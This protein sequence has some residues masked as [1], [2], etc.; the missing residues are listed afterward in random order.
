[1]GDTMDALTGFGF[2]VSSIVL[3]TRVVGC[4]Y[5]GGKVEEKI[6][7]DDPY[8][9]NIA[10]RGT[11]PFESFVGSIAAATPLLTAMS[12]RLLFLSGSPLLG[13]LLL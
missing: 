3:F 8:T 9:E 12:S 7:E 5:L 4:V 6:P 10:G 13:L 11:D 2:G 1:M